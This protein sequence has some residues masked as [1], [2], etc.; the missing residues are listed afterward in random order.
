VCVCEPLPTQVRSLA[1]ST[2]LPVQVQGRASFSV[3]QAVGGIGWGG[4][5]LTS[6]KNSGCISRGTVHA[7]T[8]SA[9]RYGCSLLSIHM[10]GPHG[11]QTRLLSDML[12]CCVLNEK[13]VKVIRYFEKKATSSDIFSVCGNGYINTRQ[14]FYFK[15]ENR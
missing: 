4:G 13:V 6:P 12:N 9:L 5:G 15:Q 7:Y 14:S 3:S 10:A 2:Q 1:L 8:Q 11:N